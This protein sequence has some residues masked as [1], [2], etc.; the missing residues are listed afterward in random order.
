M[1]GA[2]QLVSIGGMALPAQPVIELHPDGRI[3][4][5][6]GVNRLVGTFELV[7]GELRCSPLATTRMAGPPELMDLER[8]LLAALAEPTTVA[9]TSTHL[10]IGTGADQLILQPATPPA[11]DDTSG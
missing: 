5:S 9:L 11:G 6:T 7:D 2:W 4:G 8:R 1:V 10:M 3:T